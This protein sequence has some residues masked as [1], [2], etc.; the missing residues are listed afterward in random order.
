MYPY[1]CPISVDFPLVWLTSIW[2]QSSL[3]IDLSE[4]PGPPAG[5]Q[6]G[7]QIESIVIGTVRF[8]VIGRGESRH[9]VPV[10]SVF[11]EEQL[12][13]LGDLRALER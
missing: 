9:L 4:L 12:D 8:G 10:S 5:V 2:H 6:E 11:E 13:F 7:P 1:L 3:L